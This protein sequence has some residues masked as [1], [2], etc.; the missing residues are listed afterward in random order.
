DP[1]LPRIHHRQDRLARERA[2][3]EAVG[4]RSTTLPR[5]AQSIQ[6]VWRNRRQGLSERQ[7]PHPRGL[8]PPVGPRIRLGYE[9]HRSA[10][11]GNRSCPK[12]SWCIFLR[13][14]RDGLAAAEQDLFPVAAG[15]TGPWP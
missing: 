5:D 1:I 15:E 2:G 4:R 10:Q 13:C 12:A 9:L 6:G 7:L 3:F 11:G 8:L 14:P